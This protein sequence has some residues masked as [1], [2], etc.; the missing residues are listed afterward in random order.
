MVVILFMVK[1]EA[2]FFTHPLEQESFF[3]RYSAGPCPTSVLQSLEQ[4]RPNRFPGRKVSL[5]F[6]SHRFLAVEYF[7]LLPGRLFPDRLLSFG[8][9]KNQ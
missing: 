4:A 6:L 9:G 8:I 2:S 3:S 7:Q 1:K 5:F